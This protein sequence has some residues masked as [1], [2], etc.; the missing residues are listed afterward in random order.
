MA[1]ALNVGLGRVVVNGEVG[2]LTAQ[3]FKETD[4]KGVER[5]AGKMGMNVPGN[6]DRAICSECAALALRRASVRHSRIV[7][8]ISPSHS[9]SRVA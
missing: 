9:L 5:I 4:R 8:G 2:M 6:D 1:I 3:V 7:V